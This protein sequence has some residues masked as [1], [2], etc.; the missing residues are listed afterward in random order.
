MAAV[1]RLRFLGAAETL[2][3]EPLAVDL[4]SV[5]VVMLQYVASSKDSRQRLL[6][7]RQRKFTG[8]HTT[9]V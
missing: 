9:R 8:R 4:M 5:S 2:R 7:E 3:S 1:L 6:D